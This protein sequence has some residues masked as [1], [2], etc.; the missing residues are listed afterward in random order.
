[1]CT[2]ASASLVA[3]HSPAHCQQLQQLA[4]CH[5]VP[6]AKT[7]ALDSHLLNHP[8]WQAQLLQAQLWQGFDF[9]KLELLQNVNC[10]PFEKKITKSV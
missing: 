7:P 10:H 9:F 3:Q 4:Q 6:T 5:D 2:C 1:M 8:I